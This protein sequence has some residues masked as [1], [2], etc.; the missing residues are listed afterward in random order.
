MNATTQVRA[1]ALSSEAL[2]ELNRPAP[3]AATLPPTAYTSAEIYERELEF[4]F[5][6]EW[7]CVGRVEDLRKPGDYFTAQVA[8]ESLIIVRDSDQIRALSNVCRHRSCELVSGT[9]HTRFFVCP[10]HARS[11]ALNGE[12]KA[13]P[14]FDGVKNFSKKDYSLH[15]VRTEIWDGFIFVNLDRD[16][17]PLAARVS[18]MSRLE[19]EK[20]GQADMETTHTFAYDVKCNWKAYVENAMEE[21]H[22]AVVHKKTLEP[23]M[24]MLGWEELRDISDQPW[25]V[26][27]G[28]PGLS[29]SPTGKPMFPTPLPD[30]KMVIANIFPN[31]ILLCNVDSIAPMVIEP[32][33]PETCRVT[34]RMC[35]RK[36][37]AA[38]FREGDA[39]VVEVANS[40]ASS[41]PVF[42]EEDNVAT[43]AQQRGFH[44]RLAG[45]GRYC[46]HELLALRFAKW[47]T[48]KA[49][50]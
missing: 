16:A 15:T 39:A 9:G 46:Q 38:K 3:E 17:S 42:M 45:A 5:R 48:Q 24:P 1:A 6:R 27:V 41:I 35:I 43:E 47:V 31:L 28:F 44:S 25:T 20:Y 50:V 4:I 34:I 2:R 33:G 37:L 49:Y 7:I 23:I 10:Y 19:L 29:W 30:L 36:E 22:N 32:T 40:Y 26:M 13:T 8:N 11:Y 21:Y 18:D 12:L 14:N